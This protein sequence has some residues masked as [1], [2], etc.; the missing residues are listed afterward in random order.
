VE[1]EVRDVEAVDDLK[2]EY[3]P[4]INDNGAR[5]DV[6]YFQI[7]FHVS[8]VG[9]VSAKHLITPAW[10]RTKEPILKRFWLAW[11]ELRQQPQAPRLILRTNW[12][13]DPTCPLWKKL[14]EDGRLDPDFFSV[15]PS[16]NIC[17][18]R[19]RWQ[20]ACGATDSGEFL[21]FLQALRFQIS[22]RLLHETE[23]TL[24]DRCRIAGVRTMTAEVDCNAYDD[25]GMRLL[26]RGETRH[27]A[28]S[29]KKVLAQAG[30]MDSATEQ[31][32]SALEWPLLDDSLNLRVANHGNAQQAFRQL[33]RPDKTYQLLRIQGDS[34]TG[35]THLTKQFL[36]AAI[37]LSNLRCGRFDFKGSVGLDREVN[38]LAHQL[39]IDS[40]PPDS[41]VGR[42]AQI[43]IALNRD[44]RPT[45]LIFDTFEMAGEAEHW[46][47][48]NLLLDLLRCPW[49]RIVM[50]GQRT[51]ESR[52]EP[53]E[54]R[55]C[56]LVKLGR[57]TPE[58]WWDY[59][60]SREADLTLEFVRE[61][62]TRCK[63]NSF[64]LAALLCPTH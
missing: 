61:A 42:L 51:V 48:N 18:I 26:E 2:V 25:L 39:N 53:W 55:C 54:S 60:I 20:N 58:D 50:S 15:D 31:S 22:T 34:Q 57:P 47:C 17:E 64:V 29:L 7:K 30:L 43:L 19:D 32:G 3:R 9:Y 45:L 4:G 33:L 5:V 16:P 27:T 10:T 35:K 63:G 36:G 21:A 38:V 40:P 52:G 62:H 12:Q 44:P 41:L 23:D 11:K 59:G 24:R 1:M 49:L 56:D 6:D 8:Q 28:K 14:R 37:E 46:V 13:W